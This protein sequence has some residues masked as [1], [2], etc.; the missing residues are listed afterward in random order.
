MHQW[1]EEEG[2]ILSWQEK[3][4]Y[5]VMVVVALLVLKWVF[6]LVRKVSLIVDQKLPD[7]AMR[8]GHPSR[9]EGGFQ[10]D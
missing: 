9:P 3:V 1:I 5:V 7:M 8:Q 4:E 2:T 10:S 6:E